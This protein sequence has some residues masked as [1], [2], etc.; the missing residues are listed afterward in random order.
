MN[1]TEESHTID[2][3]SILIDNYK[4]TLLKSLEIFVHELIGSSSYSGK[5]GMDLL[6]MLK[7][8]LSSVHFIVV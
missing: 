5:G 8:T 2:L 4:I 3:L 6:Q 7:D 1:T